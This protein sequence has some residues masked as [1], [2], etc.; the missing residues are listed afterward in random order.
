MAST[1]IQYPIIG[2]YRQSFVSTE[3]TFVQP[4]VGA[5]AAGQALQLALRGYKSIKYTRKRTRAV[6]RGNHPD[7]LG[8]TR[9]ENEYTCEVEYLLAEYNA[10]QAALQ[11]LQAGYGDV[12]FNLVIIHAEPGADSVT[13]SV[14]GCTIDTTENESQQGPDPTMRKMEFSPLK[15]LFNGID[16]VQVPLQGAQG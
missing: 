6:V 11:S 8:K 5:S 4:A 12:F 14:I 13:D 2:G 3:V 10:I 15:V 7:P 9:G 16:D 1:P